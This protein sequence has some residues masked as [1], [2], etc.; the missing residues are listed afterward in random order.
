MPNRA[1]LTATQQKKLLIAQGALYRLRLCESKSAVRE[2]LQVDTLAKS[3]LH[4]IVSTASSAL[5]HGFSARNPAAVNFQVILPL[6]ISAISL[7]AKRK[8]LIRPALIGA[9]AVAAV[10]A[11]ARAKA[12][13]QTS[14]DASRHDMS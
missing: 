1:E 5:T 9:M 14:A 4:S 10:A 13:R 2:N 3:A 11:V 12:A 7:L 6:L 8:S